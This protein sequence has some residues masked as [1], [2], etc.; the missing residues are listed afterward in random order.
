MSLTRIHSEV[1]T[2]RD[3]FNF[4]E[5]HPAADGS[6]F[7]LAALKPADQVYTL[8]V[9]FPATYPNS[10]PNVTVR[11]PTL[12]GSK[13]RY[14]N[15]Q[16]CYMLPSLWNPGRHDLTFVLARVAKWLNKYEVYRA[17]GTWPG[18]EHTH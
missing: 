13:H 15:G 18:A 7:V 14:N 11:R 17:T 8:Q 10:P 3:T 16:I 1:A 9:D 6:V 2:A 5:C 12:V 4:V